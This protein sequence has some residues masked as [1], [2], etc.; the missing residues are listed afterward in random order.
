MGRT[1]ECGGL[2]Q[3]RAVLTAGPFGLHGSGGL[4]GK[5]STSHI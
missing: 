3:A 5:N 1:F 4:S 2:G